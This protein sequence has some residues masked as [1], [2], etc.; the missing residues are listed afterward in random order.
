MFLNGDKIYTDK[1]YRELMQALFSENAKLTQ[2]I[3][4]LITKIPF[5]KLRGLLFRLVRTNTSSRIIS[6]I[7]LHNIN[8]TIA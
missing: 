2:D 1:S 5:K 7:A 8:K 4:A 3:M 6:A